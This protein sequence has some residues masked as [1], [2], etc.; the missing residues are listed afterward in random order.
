MSMVSWGG[1]CACAHE[2]NEE[3]RYHPAKL[4]M[5]PILWMDTGGYG[6]VD[7]DVLYDAM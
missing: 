1:R 3:L 7:L 4:P 5:I 6:R 2:V